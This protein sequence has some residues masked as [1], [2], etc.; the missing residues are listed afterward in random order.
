MLQYEPEA[1][2]M[3][4]VTSSPPA[5]RTTAQYKAVLAEMLAEMAQM[6]EAMERDRVEIDRLKAET[7]DLK[8]RMRGLLAK[9]CSH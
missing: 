6:N 8:T 4:D 3:A 1:H 5:P 2:R 7:D 9:L